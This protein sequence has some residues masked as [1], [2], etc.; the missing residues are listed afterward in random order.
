MDKKGMNLII[1][2]EKENEGA[3]YWYDNGQELKEDQII[4][5]N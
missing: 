4:Q 3:K 2:M 5:Q 1:Q